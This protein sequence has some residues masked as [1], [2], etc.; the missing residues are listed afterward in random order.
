[1]LHEMALSPRRGLPETT[2]WLSHLRRNSMVSESRKGRR[3]LIGRRCWSPRHNACAYGLS[4]EF[5]A[6]ET[7]RG[8]WD[9]SGFVALIGV[10]FD[11]FVSPHT[12]S[13][14]C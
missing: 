12:L 9:L 14:E 10:L 2:V 4:F 3:M 1:M 5:Q 11:F 8:H 7:A 13:F 6:F